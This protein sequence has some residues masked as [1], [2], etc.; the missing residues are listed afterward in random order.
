MFLQALRWLKPVCKLV[1]T[2]KK[3]VSLAFHRSKGYCFMTS[4]KCD[5]N[6]CRIESPF[7]YFLQVQI[8]IRFFVSESKICS[9]SSILMYNMS[10]ETPCW[11]L[12]NKS[13]NE[14]N[15]HG[16]V[17]VHGFAVSWLNFH[18][19]LSSFLVPFAKP[20]VHRSAPKVLGS[21]EVNVFASK[22]ALRMCWRQ[23]AKNERFREYQYSGHVPNCLCGFAKNIVDSEFLNSVW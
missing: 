20:S 11:E 16:W 21:T 8:A 23:H 19:R 22:S 13:K 3:S 2:S 5:K 4:M 7:R 10:I 15:V 9:W 18:N 17:P 14:T 6:F 12:S 1:R